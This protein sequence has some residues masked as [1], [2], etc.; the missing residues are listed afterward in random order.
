VAYFATQD[1]LDAATKDDE[2]EPAF[3][4]KLSNYGFRN[5]SGSLAMFTAI[6][7]ASSLLSSL[8]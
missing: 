1:E 4:F 8:A 6:L 5:S 3:K 2:V 7:R